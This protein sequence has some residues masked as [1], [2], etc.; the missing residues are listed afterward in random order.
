MFSPRLILVLFA[1][2]A[3]SS[4]PVQAE[5]PASPIAECWKGPGVSGNWFGA[6]E[7]L[8]DRGFD[9]VGQW[10]GV[11]FGVVA[12]E[13]GTGGFYTQEINIDPRLDLAKFTRCEALQGLSAFGLLRH[14][15]TGFRANP[16]NYIKANSLFGPS[17]FEGGVGWR[18]MQFGLAYTTP[19]LFGVKDFLTIRAGW[20]APKLEFIDQPL[21]EQFV[22]AA[23]VVADGIGANVPFS[24]AFSSWGGTIEVKPVDWHYT[25]VGLFMSY[26]EASRSNNNGLMFQGY[27]PDVSQNGLWFMGETGFTPRIGTSRLPG[28][29]AL[30]A[31]LYENGGGGVDGNQFGLYLQADQMLLRE[32]SVGEKLSEQ[33]LSMFNLVSFAPP[34]NN[35]Y[36]LY[37]Q[38]GLSYEGA[39]PT[40]D[41]DKTMVGFGFAPYQQAEGASHTVFLEAGYRAQ[42]NGFTWVQP[43]V[44][45]IVQPAGTTS[46]ANAA[47]LGIYMGMDF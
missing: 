31:Y 9:L 39:V 36:P 21:S 3:V 19:E 35:P 29:Y 23:M 18:L 32:P 17:S 38:G 27:A 42:I 45:Y 40:R 37:A 8:S 43:F 15:Q 13:G 22:N 5:P 4:L 25:K 20:L 34:G 41:K 46:V 1:A 7:T 10:R 33:G 12:S 6:R 11:Y 24:A 16:N 30:G 28:K 14:R 2:A 44:Q 26:P 47:I